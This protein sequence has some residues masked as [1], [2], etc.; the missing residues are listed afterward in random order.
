MRY[1]IC[2]L[3][4]LIFPVFADAAGMIVYGDGFSFG[5][6]EPKGW[7]ADTTSGS[8]Q[9]ANVVLYE[10]GQTWADAPVVMYVNVAK[11]EKAGVA[12]LISNDS[13]RFRKR[14][15]SIKISPIEIEGKKGKVE[16]KI[17][18]CPTENYEVVSYLDVKDAICIMVMSGRNGDAVQEKLPAFK[19]F[20]KT[21]FW[22]TSNVKFK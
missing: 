20:V 2:L 14:C 18:D 11:D 17:F 9:G 22:F 15:P 4:M 21:F 10:K 19:E 13:K 12:G 5:I 16:S 7:V 3:S 1:L 6:E 8:D